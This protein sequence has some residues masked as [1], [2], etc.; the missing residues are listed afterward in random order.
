MDELDIGRAGIGGVIAD[1][2]PENVIHGLV[3]WSVDGDQI[4][5]C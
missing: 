4:R 5:S 1:E 2:G 3:K